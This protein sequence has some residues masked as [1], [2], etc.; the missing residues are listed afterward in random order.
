[1]NAK[2]ASSGANAPAAD[3]RRATRAGTGGAPRRRKSETGPSDDGRSIL[4]NLRA[5]AARGDGVASGQLGFAFAY[6]FLLLEGLESVH[7]R[8]NAKRAEFWLRRAVS[9]G[10]RDAICALADVLLS[11]RS[12]ESAAEG[13]RLLR[14]EA[15]RGDCFAAQ[16]L[17]IVHSERGNPRRC[18]FWLERTE[19]LG[20]PDLIH[21]GIARAAGYGC[22]RDLKRARRLF[23]KALSSRWSA[24]AEKE[25][26][27]GF[28]D[29]LERNREIRVEG[30]IGRC[31]P[32]PGL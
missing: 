20:D 14:Q 32:V 18:L 26:A 27:R 16:N 3:S 5:R 21:L 17:A 10:R 1:M 30:S 23:E 8:R 12:E 22:R 31:H 2:N 24:Q 13:L 28:L 25:D 29:M 4:R 15:R 9:S 7:V 11:G 6:G 19:K